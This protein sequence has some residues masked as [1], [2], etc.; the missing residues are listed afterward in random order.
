MAYTPAGNLTTSAGLAHVNVVSARKKGLDHL[1]KK[2]VFRMAAENDT[3]EKQSGKTVQWYRTNLLGPATTPTTE[4]TVG[5]SLNYTSNILQA[6][7]SQFSDFMTV[8]DLLLETSIAPEL[9]N[10]ALTLSYRA[11]Y[12]VDKMTRLVIDAEHP[13][14]SF[15]PTNPAGYARVDDFRAMRSGLQAV[16]VEP[17][18]DS[19]FLAIIHPFVTYDLTSD[20]SANGLAD[21]YKFT[22]PQGGA[23]IRMED[24]GVVTHVAGAKIIESTN[25]ATPAASTYRTYFFGKGGIGIVNLAG[26]GPSDVRDPKKQRFKIVAKQISE[27]SLPDPEGVI[28]GFVSYNFKFVPVVLEGPAGIA[29]T[30]RFKTCNHVSSI[31]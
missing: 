25:V 7:I 6:T 1:M 13:F 29:G 3:L 19:E 11:A 21:I 8:S 16:D 17:M 15:T 23:L 2:F 28:G 26:E 4:G 10:A 9:D 22:N 27:P 31:G 5:T 18:A 20:P 12:S 30:Y 24:R 14:T